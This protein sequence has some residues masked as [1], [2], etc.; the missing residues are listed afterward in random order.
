MARHKFQSHY[1]DGL[2][3]V[4][5]S[6]TVTVLNGGT[7]T[8]STIYAAESG[9]SAL[10][11][12]VV[13]TDSAGFFEFWVDTA[14]YSAGNRFDITLSKTGFNSQTYSDVVVFWGTS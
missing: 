10:S 9:G 12:G 6:G 7:S 8:A 1:T 3:N 11:G 14:D 2:G 13:T 5:Q 4:V